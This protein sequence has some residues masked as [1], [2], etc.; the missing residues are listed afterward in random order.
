MISM[1]HHTQILLVKMG[2]L[3]PFAQAEILL[4]SA[5]QVARILGHCAWI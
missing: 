3:E 1:Y 2:S 4:I 5:S